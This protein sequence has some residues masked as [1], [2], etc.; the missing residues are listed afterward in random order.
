VE[1][2]AQGRRW[3][4][5]QMPQR[6][7]QSSMDPTLHVGLGS[8]ISTVDTLQ[9]RWPDGRVSVQTDVEAR[10]RL[11]VRQAEAGD[12][13]ALAFKRSSST[14]TGEAGA[15]LADITE[16]IG[17]DWKHEESSYDDFARS[18]LLFHMRSTEGP[19]LCVGDVN[20]DRMDD[21]YVGGARDQPGVLFVQGRDGRFRRTHQP[22]LENDR[23][24]EDTDC[25]FFD[26]DG[27]GIPELYVASGSS[28]FAAGSEQLADRLYRIGREGEL[29]RLEDALPRLA[30]GPTPTGVVRA[31]DVDGDG[32][33]DLF[34]GSRMASF[35][36]DTGYGVPVG[37][38][39]FENDGAGRFE[40]AT[41]R[42]AP[43]LRAQE[44][45]AAGVTDAAWG[46]LNGDG[47]PDLLVAGEWIP[48]TVFFNRG[49]RLE[50]ADSKSVGLDGTRGWWQSLALA[51]LNGDGVLD[52]VGGNHGLNSHF[53]AGRERPVE[54]WAGDFNRSGR[55]DQIFASH[56]DE[57]GP[58]P[59]AL[60]HNLI[61]QLPYLTSRY[62]TFA[63]YAGKTVMEIFSEDDLEEAEHYWADQLASVIGWNDGEGR[64]RIDPLPFG[65]QLAPVYAILAE[66]LDG[67]DVPE[68]LVGGNLHAVRPQAGPYDAGY[69]TVLRQDTTG[70]YRT[71]S[72]QESGFFSPGEIRAIR[73]LQHNGQT[74]ILVGRNDDHLQVFRVAAQ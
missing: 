68:I 5:E 22:A 23:L 12:H 39:L 52:L 73:S 50:R 47:T 18:P 74:L 19:A 3:Y 13:A 55:I 35:G 38:F 57:G 9:V 34:V 69:G 70:T 64:F 71:L 43:H 60:R 62:P 45:R 16:G 72:S 41:D 46:D 10:Q 31:A 14:N 1:L 67:D 65:A 53:R 4:A 30:D 58:Y 48:L 40:D 36:V 42:M 37:G 21:V 25:E 2:E 8:G 44:F 11:V 24:A 6:G 17:I 20:G 26:A 51:D 63:D 15:L 33:Q 32:D 59:V 49:G 56:N 7:F 61:H 54:M 66:D 27:D 29:V 28:E